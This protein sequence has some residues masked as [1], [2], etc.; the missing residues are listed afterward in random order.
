MNNVILYNI[1]HHANILNGPEDDGGQLI[2][3]CWCSDSNCQ[4]F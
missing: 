4:A 2:R 3:Y 1:D